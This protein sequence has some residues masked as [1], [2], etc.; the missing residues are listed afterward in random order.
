MTSTDQVRVSSPVAR[1]IWLDAV[2]ADPEALVT[3]TPGWFD[4]MAEAHPYQDASRCYQWESGRRLILPAV[5]R[6]WTTP[7]RSAELAWP[8]DWGIG[9]VLAPGGPVTAMEATAVFEDLGRRPDAIAYLRP[10]PRADPVWRATAPDSVRLHPRTTHVLDLTGG[11]DTVWQ[12][13]FTGRARTALRKAERSGLT[14]ER[15]NNTRLLNDFRQLYELSVRRW[16][17]Q[18]GIDHQRA[19]RRAELTDPRRNFAAVA[20]NLGTDCV[21]WLA[22]LA[23]APVAGAITLWHGP[24]AKY[25]R[26]AMDKSA[27]ATSGPTLLQ[28]LAIR[29]ACERGCHSYHMG[30]SRPG[31]SVARFKEMFGARPHQ[32]AGY[33]IGPA[34]RDSAGLGSARRTLSRRLPERGTGTSP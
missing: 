11:F 21:L 6:R 5:R 15:G 1:D 17:D 23:G 9:G 32:G 28:V 8:T 31:D 10:A 2:A 3:Q 16:A 22:Y 27:A 18:S 14:V 34:T 25:W 19:V 24:H 13:R 20:R 26:G 4:A 12:Q 33:W 7:S 30:D 29:E